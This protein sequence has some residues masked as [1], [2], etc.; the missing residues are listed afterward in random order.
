MS[1]SA[2]KWK[3]STSTLAT[4]SQRGT[5]LFDLTEGSKLVSGCCSPHVALDNGPY[6]RQV[7]ICFKSTIDNGTQL[8]PHNSISTSIHH[9]PYLRQVT[10][11]N[12]QSTAGLNS[13][14]T[15]ASASLLIVLAYT[16]LPIVLFQITKRLSVIERT[17]EKTSGKNPTISALG[18][19][20]VP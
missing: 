6:L 7:S 12:L 3:C 20:K 19:G 15:T 1:R 14:L 8:F 2:P 16:Q 10:V 18:C 9:N 11:P 17:C 4:Q 13:F 5:P